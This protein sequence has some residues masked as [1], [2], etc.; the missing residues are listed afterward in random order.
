MSEPKRLCS[1]A[2]E[3]MRQQN[4]Q[5]HALSCTECQAFVAYLETLSDPEAREYVSKMSEEMT[6]DKTEIIRN[7][8]RE[9]F[10]SEALDRRVL[11][12]KYGKVWNT[13]E[14]SQDFD[15]E[16]FL[17]PYVVVRRKTDGK[18]GSLQFQ[19]N[20]RFYFNWEEYNS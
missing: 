16:G 11:Q 8:E 20:P 4:W 18:R 5:A 12:L 9:H 19:H 10:N 3:A 7:M 14:L 13:A 15:V 17:A 1:A 2:I 6:G